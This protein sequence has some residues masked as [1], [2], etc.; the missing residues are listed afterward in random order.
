MAAS[1]GLEPLF[2]KVDVKNIQQLRAYI[3]TIIIK[4]IRWKKLS[5]LPQL[6]I[7]YMKL[8]AYEVISLSMIYRLSGPFYMQ[9][10][11]FQVGA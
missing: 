5:A 7:F 10:K 11:L 9:I 8:M 1:Y 4:M 6:L 2:F 3:K